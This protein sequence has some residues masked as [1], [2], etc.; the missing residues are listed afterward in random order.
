MQK[1]RVNDILLGPL[2]RPALQWLAQRMPAWVTPN[3]LTGV[4]VFAGFLIAITYYL[5]KDD[6]RFL[7]L[8]NLAF[9]LNWF[10]DSLDGSLARW[11]KIE[12]PK[13]GYFIDHTSDALT[14]SVICI[15]LG[16]SPF[17]D[18]AYALFVLVGYLLMMIFSYV[19]TISTGV[20]KISYGK[21]GPT[22]IR[23]LYILANVYFMYGSN[24]TLQ[25]A[26]RPITLFNGVPL[27][28]GFGLILYFIFFS[29]REGRQIS[30]QDPPNR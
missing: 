21:I 13:F 1:E 28:V 6:V 26:G 12:R 24:V 8:T 29:I 22:E 25:I 9:V 11:R 3:H 23:I 27:V 18:M 5:S 4:G 30:R 16:L 15:G 14:S 17:I 10:G 7:W 19:L 2:E 20:F